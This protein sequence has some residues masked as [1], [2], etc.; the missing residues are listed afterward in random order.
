[1]STTTN[2][3]F[4]SNGD[5]LINILSTKVDPSSY[6]T[7]YY[8]ST[9]ISYT[10]STILMNSTTYC[11]LTIYDVNNTHSING[12]LNTGMITFNVDI[13]KIYYAVIG[14]GGGGSNGYHV[15]TPIALDYGYGGGGASG[16]YT[17]GNTSVNTGDS[18]Y[19]MI[20]S[21]GSGCNNNNNLYVPSSG[22]QTN[23][24]LVPVNGSSITLASPS[25]G[26]PGNNNSS[27]NG[28]SV[29]G[30][31]G[32]AG[33]SGTTYSNGSEVSITFNDDNGNPIYTTYISGGGSVSYPEYGGSAGTATSGGGGISGGNSPNRTGGN[34]ILPNYGC[35]GGGVFIGSGNS[36][37][38]GNG[39]AGAVILVFEAPSV[40]AN[41]TNYSYYDTS[42]SSYQDL[43]TLFTPQLVNP[44]S[45]YTTTNFL[46]KNYMSLWS[47][48]PNIYD[49]GQIFINNP[50]NPVI[51]AYNELSYTNGLP[52]TL[53]ENFSLPLSYN[54]IN[55]I[56]Y[57]A[58]GSG[59][60]PSSDSSCYGGGG[61]GAF[62][63]AI[64]IPYL[65]SDSNSSVY[66]TSI[67]YLIAQHGSTSSN[68]Y[69]TLTYSDSTY[70]TLTA[71]TG[72][73]VTST[74]TGQGGA[75]GIVSIVN[76][77]I[78]YYNCNKYL[79]G[80]SGGATGN[81]GT[82]NGYTCSGSGSSNTSPYNPID[83]PN[84]I[85]NYFYI[86]SLQS[87]ISINSQGGGSNN[88]VSGYGAGG[89]ATP[90]NYVGNANS[91]RS[92]SNGYIVYYLS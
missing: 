58:G 33:G 57:G 2:T 56:I 11:V 71:G 28:G 82:N 27:G 75:G 85:N 41:I 12:V 50:I 77:T 16:N 72:T 84:G 47:T 26:N 51:P 91:Y 45:N 52:I 19:A 1:M 42:S 87:S 90:S 22:A 55:F 69:V 10:T 80:T 23:L 6:F 83:N 4:V 59:N 54:Y 44:G 8:Y 74:S 37:T 34:T 66:I 14:G 35:G 79:N 65:Y 24:N 89:A 73:S 29:G 86:P 64:N 76:T 70:I 81:S 49:L 9:I 92:G 31:N 36:N 38:S 18:L 62:I 7:F 39:A 20:G 88:M 60:T 17:I 63:Y 43:N 67:N 46:C 15:T 40:Q 13:P 5:D 78:F 30:G 32:A 53:I 25:G 48:T 61:A 21:G 3:N 68:T